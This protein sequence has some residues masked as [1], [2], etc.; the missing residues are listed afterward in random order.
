MCQHKP[1]IIPGATY[2]PSTV[3]IVLFKHYNYSSKSRSQQYNDM[4]L[5]PFSSLTKDTPTAAAVPPPLFFTFQRPKCRESEQYFSVSEH[6]AY[7]CYSLLQIG[8][9]TF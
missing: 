1:D 3:R 6:K 4:A 5:V 2:V 7:T 8:R 9:K